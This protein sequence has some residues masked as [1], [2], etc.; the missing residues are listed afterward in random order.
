MYVYTSDLRAGD[1]P[2]PAPPVAEPRVSAQ[3]HAA[4]LLPRHAPRGTKGTVDSAPS[5]LG[6]PLFLRLELFAEDRG[7]F[8]LH[9]RPRDGRVGQRALLSARTVNLKT[10]SRLHSMP[11]IQRRTQDKL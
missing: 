8:S 11:S 2:A 9:E 4:A 3:P 6:L 7:D 1:A 5:A 10:T